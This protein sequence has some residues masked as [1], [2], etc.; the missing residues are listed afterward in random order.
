MFE[1]DECPR[2]D[3][4]LEKLAKLPTVFRKGGTVT[5]GNSSPINDGSAAALD[6]S[7]VENMEPPPFFV[8]F[9][10]PKP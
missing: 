1:K 10:G 7:C 8:T 9:A 5:A 4:T 3:T 6:T 2:D